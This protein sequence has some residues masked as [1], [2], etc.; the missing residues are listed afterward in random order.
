[1]LR[2]LMCQLRNRQMMAQPRR[3]KKRM[4]KKTSNADTNLTAKEFTGSDL[5]CRTN[6]G[7]ASYRVCMG[8]LRFTAIFRAIL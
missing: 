1:M 8:F 2:F 5:R 7:V 3:N 6:M 4:T